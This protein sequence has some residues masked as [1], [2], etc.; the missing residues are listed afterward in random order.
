MFVPPEDARKEHKGHG[1]TSNITTKYGPHKSGVSVSPKG[2]SGASCVFIMKSPRPTIP[3]VIATSEQALAAGKSNHNNGNPISNDS[4][5]VNE[6]EKIECEIPQNIDADLNVAALKI[7]AIQRGRKARKEVE[8]K[9]KEERKKQE[10]AAKS[11]QKVYRGGKDRAKVQQL[12]KTQEEEAAVKLQKV[13]RGFLFCSLQFEN[14]KTLP[15]KKKN[16]CKKKKK[17]F[18]FFFCIYLV[19]TGIYQRPSSKKTLRKGEINED[20]C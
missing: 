7:Q 5:V 12:K 4:I 14:G 2:S 1:S 6:E 16:S 20:P 17:S 19:V 13:A 11:I 9:V 3:Q 10:E 8:L 18:I 15:K